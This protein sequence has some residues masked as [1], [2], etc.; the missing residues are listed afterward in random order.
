MSSFGDP[1]NRVCP[2]SCQ[3][4][5]G[6]TQSEWSGPWNVSPSLHFHYVISRSRSSPWT[7]NLGTL[8]F[9]NLGLCQAQSF[10]F[11]FWFF[12]H[13]QWHHISLLALGISPRGDWGTL[14]GDEHQ[15]QVSHLLC[16]SVFLVMTHLFSTL[17]FENS[18]KPKKEKIIS[19]NNLCATIV[20]FISF[21]PP[22]DEGKYEKPIR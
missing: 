20:F 7:D 19:E 11:S 16:W 5:P 12:G 17:S 22:R 18:N 15:T 10:S 3:I 14:W 4:F 2:I 13:I 8:S 21:F 1:G 9:C 6:R